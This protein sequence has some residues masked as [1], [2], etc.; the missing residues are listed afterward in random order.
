MAKQ[1]KASKIPPELAAPLGNNTN[2]S[3]ARMSRGLQADKRISNYRILST[4]RSLY[5][6]QAKRDGL[7]PYDFHKT[8]KCR[9]VRISQNVTVKAK[10]GSGS[11]DGL[12]RCGRVWTCPVCA[13]SIQEQRRVE[14][15]KAVTWAYTNGLK[16]IMV[17]F[18]H[19]HNR[20]NL[21]KLKDTLKRKG[22]VLSDLR[23]TR[24]WKQLKDSTYEG[25][26]RSL[27]VTIGANGWHVHTHE[28]LFVD[29]SADAEKILA[30]IKKRY[31]ELCIKHGLL[32]GSD[33]AK[34]EAFNSHAV[35]VMDNATC[36]A[37]LAKTEASSTWGVDAEMAK[38]NRKT[39]R[40]QRTKNVYT[41]IEN[42]SPFNDRLWLEYTKAMHRQK[43]LQWSV[44]LKDKVGIDDVQDDEIISNESS[45]MDVLGVLT[46]K[47]WDYIAKHKEQANV[48]NLLDSEPDKPFNKAELIT[49]IN[50]YLK[51][52]KLGRLRMI[53]LV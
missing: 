7:Q 10:Q 11:L 22:K 23:T 34:I 4:I 5:F 15:G 6:D 36:S 28:L 25:F 3:A 39:G 46:P 47:Q 21:F 27:E 40:A 48:L 33:Q 18:T 43:Q 37:Y 13:A 32:D 24:A 31:K 49:R 29:R 26:I 52:R 19:P 2:K 38:A 51:L 35:D 17:T 20:D 8:S 9:Q 50:K 41:L 12:V 16:A 44:G 1:L 42:R 30:P 45:E 53:R 14:I